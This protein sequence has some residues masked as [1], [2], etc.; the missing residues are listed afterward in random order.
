MGFNQKVYEVVKRIPEGRVSTYGEIAFLIQKSL[1]CQ[2]YGGQAKLKGYDNPTALARAVGNA[3]H[4]NKDSSVPCHRIVDRSGRI[5]PNF[6]LGGAV[7]Q[8][9]RLIA[10]GVEFKSEMNVDL[11]S[12]LW[13]ENA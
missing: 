13:Q 2:D 6:G 8:R 3:L 12:C 11:S 7:E 9:R 4:K 10:E 1:L 5:A